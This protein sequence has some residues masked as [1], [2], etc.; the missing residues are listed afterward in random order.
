[1]K[2]LLFIYYMLFSQ[3]SN[4]IKINTRRHYYK[5][6]SF[7]QEKYINSIEKVLNKKA[8]IKFTKIQSGDLKDTNADISELTK[9]F[10]YKPKISVYS[11]VKK[12]IDWYKNYYQ[13][14]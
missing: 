13:V 3:L 10:K 6:K 5:A 14:K 12:F 1:M 11:G 9:K 7:T 2:I 4:S 8:K